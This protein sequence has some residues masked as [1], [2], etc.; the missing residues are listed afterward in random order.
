[1]KCEK[2]FLEICLVTPSNLH[3]IFG[4][5]DFITALA[6][7]LV[8]YTITDVRFRFRI[9]IAQHSLHSLTFYLIGILGSAVLLTDVWIAQKWYV[10]AA[11][12]MFVSQPI[13]RALLGASFLS[14]PMAWFYYGYIRPPVFGRDN[15]EKFAQL[16][17]GI[18]LRGSDAELAVIAHE[19]ARSAPTLV[20]LC[21]PI[22]RKRRN[23]NEEGRKD[24]HKPD[25]SDYAHDL[26]LLLANRKLCRHILASSPITAM[27]IFEEMTANEKYAIPIGLF[28][29]NIS[30]EA[31][32][33]K[34]SVLYHEGDVLISGLMG[35]RK[36]FSKALYGNYGLVES[37]ATYGR[38][39][40][41][42][43]NEMVRSWDAQQWEMYGK[44]VLITLSDY[45]NKGNWGYHSYALYRSL[46]GFE[47]SC[48]DI[49]KLRDGEDC[50][51][52][53]IL[54]RLEAVVEFAKEAVNLI[55][56]MDPLP[57][58]LLRV[59]RGSHPGDFDLYD[60]IANVMFEIILSA[61]SVKASPDTSWMIHHNTVWGE[62]FGLTANSKAWRIVHHKLRRLLYDEIAKLNHTPNYKSSRI[63]G[64]CLNVLGPVFRKNGRVF[65][66]TNALHKAVLAWTR[67][68][69]LKLNKENPEVAESCLIG[70]ITFDSQGL[71]IVKTYRKDLE[72]EPPKEYLELPP[73]GHTDSLEKAE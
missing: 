18:I 23:D 13:W 45:L 61:A 66:E 68:N 56:K 9:G 62:F 48:I 36:D 34:D 51:S 2:E 22:E 57:S 38:S 4:F 58:T 6:L 67:K 43:P 12:E 63:L 16:L 55:G 53:D 32:L 19:L 69:Y 65:K 44:V 26:L 29:S 47:H 5:S 64:F 39:Q 54:R 40:L 21:R 30:T 11:I 10:P 37:L 41:D 71:R 31:I 50:Y 59:R 28:A 14:L 25:A 8:V 49:Y 7:L 35:S 17:Y 52:S 20:T 42:I 15:Y 46:K 33:N 3:S 70:S 27:A 72:K 73:M 60:H 24:R 1:M